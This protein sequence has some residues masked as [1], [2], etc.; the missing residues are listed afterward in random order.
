[1]GTRSRTRMRACM[2]AGECRLQLP[3]RDDSTPPTLQ[4]MGPE[5]A[6]AYRHVYDAQWSEERDLCSYEVLSRSILCY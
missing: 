1:M 6:P 4:Q 5:R 3:V 2:E